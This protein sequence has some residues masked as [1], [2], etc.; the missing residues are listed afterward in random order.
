MEWTP[1]DRMSPTGQKLLAYLKQREHTLLRS[2]RSAT[3]TDAQT[4]FLRGQLHEGEL[5]I[6]EFDT[7]PSLTS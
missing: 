4:G 5:L 1:L 6:K 7:A 3:N 2:L